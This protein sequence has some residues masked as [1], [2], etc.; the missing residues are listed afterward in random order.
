M[1]VWHGMNFMPAWNYLHATR[2]P[3][4]WCLATGVRRGREWDAADNKA[5]I[6]VCD[7]QLI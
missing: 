2:H 5:H 3:D 7:G 4:V 6:G 1:R